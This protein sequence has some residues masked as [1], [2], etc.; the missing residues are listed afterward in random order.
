MQCGHAITILPR[1][2]EGPYDTRTNRVIRRYWEYRDYFPR[3]WQESLLR[4]ESDGLP[5]IH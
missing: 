1:V 3:V 4:G 2:L 5:L